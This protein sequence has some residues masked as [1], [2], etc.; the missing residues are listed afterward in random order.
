[1]KTSF[2]VATLA[3]FTQAYYLDEFVLDAP[4]GMDPAEPT[5]RYTDADGYEE[6][7]DYDN[8]SP[9]CE[10]KV[11]EFDDYCHNADGG[12]QK[13]SDFRVNG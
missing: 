13:Y 5:P 4:D 8:L 11:M 7:A 10:A 3:A 9:E 12:D 6:G 2:A 1:M